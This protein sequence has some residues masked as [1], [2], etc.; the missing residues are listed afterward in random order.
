M[1][2]I[3]VQPLKER[4]RGLDHGRRELPAV[5]DP[6]VDRHHLIDIAGRLVPIRRGKLELHRHGHTF[7][8]MLR[9]LLRSVYGRSRRRGEKVLAVHCSSL[10]IGISSSA[11]WIVYSKIVVAGTASL[12]PSATTTT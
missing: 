5:A 1:A 8:R 9:P 2:E 3:D 7:G 4:R 10:P 12:R 11:A 6:R